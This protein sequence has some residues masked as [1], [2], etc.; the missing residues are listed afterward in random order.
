MRQWVAGR[1]PAESRTWPP[2][3]GLARK[4]RTA[5]S[6]DTKIFRHPTFQIARPSYARANLPDFPLY[7]RGVLSLIIDAVQ[8]NA[9]TQM[10]SAA[11]VAEPFIDA[12]DD[13][14]D[15][16][17][18]RVSFL[19]DSLGRASRG[20]D[21]AWNLSNVL[22]TV[23]NHFRGKAGRISSA[24]RD[25]LLG[26]IVRASM[27]APKYLPRSYNPDQ[28]GAGMRALA[29]LVM[30]WAEP[31]ER[32]ERRSKHTLCDLVA[33]A[34]MFRN[35]LHNV[36]LLEEIEQRAWE[37]RDTEIQKLLKLG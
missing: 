9:G 25:L 21:S 22:E 3:D 27:T 26:D 20:E 10:P 36:S 7:N 6:V 31:Q 28:I 35:D 29:G 37:R 34:R 19:S 2:G 30:I 5:S 18:Y 14:Q 15:D 8:W 32:T 33:Y 12:A 1:A 17:D 23:D 24:Q 11:K 16:I 4:A 13:M